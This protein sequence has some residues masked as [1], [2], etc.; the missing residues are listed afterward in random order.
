MSSGMQ[1]GFT[2]AEMAAVIL[3][4]GVLLAM[5]AQ[6]SIPIMRDA[7]RIET[8][9]KLENIAKA[10]DFYAAQNL[11]VPCPA[12]PDFAEDKEPFGAEEGSGPGGKIVPMDCGTDAKEWEGIVPFRTLGIPVD[13]IKD[14]GHFI[15]YAIS[16]AFAQDVSNEKIPVHAR[17][18]TADWFN[19]GIVYGPN[20]NDPKTNKQAVNVLLTKN[21]RKA[22]FCCS[23]SLL[24]DDLM[25]L[26][27]HDKPQI[28]IAR[29]TNADSYK[30]ANVP[31][32]DPAK[33][34]AVIPDNDR[35]IAPVY[36]LISHGMWGE[37]SF[38]GNGRAKTS[39]WR[40][41]P[42]EKQ[43]ASGEGKYVEIP[44]PERTGKEKSFDD[45]VVWRTQ[46]MIFAAQNG[47]CSLP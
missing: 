20:I 42:A 18:R 24:T 12:A 47:S 21:A 45:T 10:I 5:A 33:P 19:A 46:D 26:D 4:S 34:G 36:V 8:Q 30:P 1:S 27:G 28:A 31:F 2:L 32:P 39:G 3:I 37:G 44:V 23:G 22:R 15:T 11:R 25:I 6:M 43:N 35:V 16:P 7:R 41:T 38:S 14:N 29:Q 17:C 13:W 40:M 9:A